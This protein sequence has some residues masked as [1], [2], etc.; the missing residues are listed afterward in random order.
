MSQEVPLKA[1]SVIRL[2]VDLDESRIP[3]TIHWSSSDGQQT[4]GSPCGAFLLSVWDPKAG[5]TLRIDLWTKDMQKDEMDLLFFQTFLTLS[6]TY[7]RA[8]GDAELTNMIREFGYAF[9][10]KAKLIRV[11]DE[12]PLPIPRKPDPS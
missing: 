7:S 12:N 6:E 9:G 8:N 11:A 10:E 2:D 3:E 1:K 5:Q 4:E